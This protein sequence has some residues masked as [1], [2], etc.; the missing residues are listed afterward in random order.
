MLH[1]LSSILTWYN[2]ID[3]GAVHIL[4]SEDRRNFH[5]SVRELVA[6]IYKILHRTHAS[7]VVAI[8]CE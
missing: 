4:L 6:F 3:L 8:Q 5:H 1:T 2:N 7:P